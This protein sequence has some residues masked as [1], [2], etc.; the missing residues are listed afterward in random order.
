L[1]AVRTPDCTPIENY[2][3]VKQTDIGIARDPRFAYN[4]EVN[5]EMPIR[6]QAYKLQPEEEEWLDEY[7]N[8]LIKKEVIAPIQPDEHPMFV[9]PLLL[10]PNA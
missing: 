5:N 6:H 4:L 1:V 9:T 3:A 10:V 8:D 2:L 7:L